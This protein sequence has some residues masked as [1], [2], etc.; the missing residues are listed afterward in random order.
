MTL[1]IEP[2]FSLKKREVWMLQNG[3]TISTQ[4][5]SPAAHFEHTILVT[6]EGYEILTGESE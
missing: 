5:K 2:M 4:D 3:W 6:N 1:A